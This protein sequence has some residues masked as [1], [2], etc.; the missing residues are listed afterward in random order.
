MPQKKKH[1]ENR[2]ESAL[3]ELEE[4]IEAMDAGDLS[5]EALISHYEKGAKLINDCE[6]ILDTARKRLDL[7]QVKSLTK[8]EPESSIHSDS[9]DSE[10]N[11]TISND[12]DEI[13]LF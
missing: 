13:R 4:M 11:N 3:S 9:E 10:S 8:N 6:S 5:L 2:F 1:A 12:D 7:I